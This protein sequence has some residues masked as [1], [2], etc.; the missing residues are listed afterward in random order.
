MTDNDRELERRLEELEREARSLREKA[1][2][3]PVLLE[4]V[5]DLENERAAL[6][7]LPQ[8]VWELKG[9]V[10]TLTGIVNARVDT[11]VTN[12]ADPPPEQARTVDTLIKFASLVLVPILVAL[13][14][15]YF[16]LKAGLAGK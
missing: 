3:I 9:M 8:T 16:A 6:S 2:R 11:T 15:G 14:G 4:R 10:A 5:D 7:R 13:I 12:P 1:E